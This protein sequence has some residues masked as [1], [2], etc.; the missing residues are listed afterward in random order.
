V[1]RRRA[2]SNRRSRAAPHFGPWLWLCA[3]VAL[4]APAIAIAWLERSPPS[5]EDP[6]LLRPVRANVPFRDEVFGLIIAAEGTDR[7][8]DPYDCTLAYLKA[9]KPLT[10]MTL[11]ET[12][13]WGEQVRRIWLGMGEGVPSSAKGAF[14]LENET[15]RE[16]MRALR[17]SGR[18][19]FTATTQKR[20][21]VWVARTQGL[22]A[23]NGFLSHPHEL[24]LAAKDLGMVSPDER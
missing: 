21:A 16:A 19:R 14:Q 20:I 8:G 5:V 22:G 24:S 17:L 23:W 2:K 7:D 15:E 10:A 11:D 3:P 13:A 18:E 4:C 1:K 6:A 12:L 9:P